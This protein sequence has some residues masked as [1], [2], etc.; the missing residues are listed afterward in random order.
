MKIKIEYEAAPEIIE[1]DVSS[2]AKT[3]ETESEIGSD[4]ASA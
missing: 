1:E 3:N 4:E 2:S